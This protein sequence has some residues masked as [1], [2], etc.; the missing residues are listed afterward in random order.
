MRLSVQHGCKLGVLR[1]HHKSV[2]RRHFLGAVARGLTSPNAILRGRSVLCIAKS[3]R[4]VGLFTR[5]CLLRVL[6]RRAARRTGGSTGSLSFCSVNVTRVIL[7]P[8]SGL[9]GRAVGKTNFHSGFGIGML[10]VHQGGRCLL[11]SLN[12]RQVRDK[13]ILLIRNA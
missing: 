1:I 3:F 11:R 10:N 5:S 4:G 13:S 8:S 2:S 7:V 9:V 6:S 12:G